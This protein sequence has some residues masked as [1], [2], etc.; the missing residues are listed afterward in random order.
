MANLG[1]YKLTIGGS[2]FG[3]YTDIIEPAGNAGGP[4]ILPILGYG[5]TAP[6][7]LNLGNL[8]IPRRYQMTREH[9]TNASAQTWYQT[10][11]ATWSGVFDCIIAHT[12]YTGTETT[13]TVAGAKVEIAVDPPI[14]VTTFTKITITGGASS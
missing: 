3:T 4:N 11:V 1:T 7:Y 12:D 5:A 9:A 10:A 13:F 14:G 6:V 2:V 8:Q